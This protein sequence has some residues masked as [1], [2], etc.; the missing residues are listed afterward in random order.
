[1]VSTIF[2]TCRFCPLILLLLWL[3]RARNSAGSTRLLRP[4]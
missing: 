4:F 2:K 3:C 1:L